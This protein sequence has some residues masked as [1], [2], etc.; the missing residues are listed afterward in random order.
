MLR[1]GIGKVSGVLLDLS[2][3]LY[4]DKTPTRGALA[5]LGR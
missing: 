5:S 1:G 4:I 2:G 3:T